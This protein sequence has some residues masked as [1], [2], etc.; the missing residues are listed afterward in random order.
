MALSRWLYALP[1]VLPT[2]LMLR[3]WVMQAPV[4]AFIE[5]V[6]SQ[7][8]YVLKNGTSVPIQTAVFGIPILD[9]AF[10]PLAIIFSPLAFYEDP[11]AWWQCVVFLT[12]G[13]SIGTLLMFESLRNANQG[14]LFQ[15]AFFLP[16]FLGQFVTLGAV[17]PLYL[18][19]F[20]ALSPLSKYST[21]NARQFDLAGVAAALPSTFAT[22]LFP[23]GISFFHP[24]LEVRHLANW[25]WQIFPIT[26]SILLFALSS[27]IRPF[28]ASRQTEPVQQHSKTSINVRGGIMATVSAASYWYMLLFSPLPVSELFFPKYFIE[29]PE[30]ALTATFTLLQ[31]DYISASGT[32]LLWLAYNFGDLKNAG[33]CRLSWARIILYSVA[34]G[35]V[36]GPG[37]LVWVGW[38]ARENMMAKLE[39][40]KTG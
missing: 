15:A 1:L 38:L 35:V 29:L 20:Y 25:Y 8:R 37:V 21:A 12:D 14:T 18:Y 13:A 31:Y 36:G 16:T 10:S 9:K 30:D 39:H 33:V 2:A 3:A 34:I 32:V 24:N 11:R 5:E 23:L 40:A 17:A 7:G 28:V 19:L 26:G 6:A 22:F 27:A 4:G